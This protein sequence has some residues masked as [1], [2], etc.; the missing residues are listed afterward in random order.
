MRPSS[1]RAFQPELF[2]HCA[3]ALGEDGGRHV[4]ARLIDQFAGKVLRFADD[5][6]VVERA[7]Q[8][9]LVRAR[10]GG[11]RELLHAL[12]FAVGAISVGI[13]VADNSSLGHG[14]WSVFF[15]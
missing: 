11:D 9:S 5:A 14:A 8:S 13:E 6:A 3:G 2:A 1:T 7:L 4:I 12:V 10:G 15:S